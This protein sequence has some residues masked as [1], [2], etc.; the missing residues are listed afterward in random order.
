MRSRKAEAVKILP[1]D[2]VER[3]QEHFTGGY[4]YVPS[5]M[6]AKRLLRNMEIIRMFNAGKTVTEISETFLLTRT[7]I[8]YILK[9]A[10]RNPGGGSHAG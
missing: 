1:P 3:I 10:K 5:R 4:L 6:K 2:L 7:G 9:A 8:R